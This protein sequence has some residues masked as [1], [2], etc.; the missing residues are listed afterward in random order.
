MALTSYLRADRVSC[1]SLA[2]I[3]QA[4]ADFSLQE[5]VFRSR[6]IGLVP[7]FESEPG[8][9]ALICGQGSLSAI[10]SMIL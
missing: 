2:L 9:P 7:A 8:F 10:P 5:V 4:L 6:R 1:Q 3:G